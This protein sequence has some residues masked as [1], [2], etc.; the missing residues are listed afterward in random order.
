MGLSLGIV[1]LP[2]VG[3]STLFNALTRKQVPAENYP[4][5]TIDPSVGIVGVPDPTLERLA[6]MSVSR[7]TIPAVVEFVDIAGLVRGAAQGEGLGNQFLA[8]IREV[9][10]IV[11]VVRIFEDTNITHV[12]GEIDP[13]RDIA[14]IHYEL[15]LADVET[16][17]KRL[18]ALE[19]DRKRQDKIAE[20]KYAAYKKLEQTLLSGKRAAQALLSPE[21]LAL[22]QEAHLLTMK[23]VLFA[24]NASLTG[25]NLHEHRQDPRW[26][27]LMNTLEEEEAQWVVVYAGLEAE[28]ADL[29]PLD[30]ASLRKE[31]GVLDDG[32]RDLIRAAH[33]TLNRIT[34]YTTGEKESRAWSIPHGATAPEAGAA[35]HTDFRDR[36]IRAEVIS[37]QKLLEAGSYAAAREGGLVRTEGKEYVVQDGDVMLFRIASSQGG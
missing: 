22:T 21:E 26:K 31:F 3:K 28:L 1:G 4:F 34:F 15:I 27:A 30:R 36:F 12:E 2:N 7:E 6:Q 16:V 14:T 35:I 33:T 9:D 29:D 8:H 10:A 5:C 17:R 24:F 13:A 20:Q 23:P 32:L 18:A 37:A 25:I 19:K 11:H